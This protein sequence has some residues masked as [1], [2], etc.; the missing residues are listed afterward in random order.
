[1]LQLFWKGIQETLYMVLV[2]M[3]IS[4]LIGTPLGV[5]L[6]VTDGNGICKNTAVNTV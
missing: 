1:M 2:S 4:Y 6:Y 5:I 3:G